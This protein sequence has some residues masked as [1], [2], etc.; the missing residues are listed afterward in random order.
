MSKIRNAPYI[1]TQGT[2]VH[3]TVGAVLID[4]DEDEPKWIP[5]SCLEDWPDKGEFGEVIILESLAIEKGI[6]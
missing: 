4:F 6:I 1:T 5:K 2:T 3:Y